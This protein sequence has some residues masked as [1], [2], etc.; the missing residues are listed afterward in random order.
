MDSAIVEK[1]NGGLLF[2]YTAK[3][4]REFYENLECYLGE[5]FRDVKFSI[6]VCAEEIGYFEVEYLTGV[7]LSSFERTVVFSQ[8]LDEVCRGVGKSV[9]ESGDGIS[10]VV[11]GKKLDVFSSKVI[12]AAGGVLGLLVLHSRCELEGDGDLQGIEFVFGH[13][14][15]AYGYIA[16]RDLVA[17]RLLGC[18]AKLEGIGEISGILGEFDL[19]S[20]CAQL[21]SLYISLTEAQVGSIVL[22]GALGSDVEWGLSRC[23]LDQIRNVAGKPVREIVLESGEALLIPRYGPEAGFEAV[24]G[25]GIGSFLC[26]PLV[27]KDKVLGTVNLINASS[28]KGRVFSSLDVATVVTISSLAASAIENVILHNELIEREHIKASLQIARSIQQGMYPVKGLVIP[29]YEMAWVTRCCDETGGD[30]F[31]LFELG[32]GHAAFAIGDVSGHGIGAAL[33]MASGRANLRALLSVKV[34]LRDVVDRLNDLLARDMDDAMFMTL[35]LGSLNHR[36]HVL[37]F[38]NAGHDQPILLRR[39]RGFTE[40]LDTTGLPVG[41]MAGWSFEVRSVAPLEPGDVLVL[42][43]DGVWEAT[44][45]QGERFGKDRLRE[46]LVTAGNESPQQLIDAILKAVE[47]YADGCVH[48]DD[49]TLLVLKRVE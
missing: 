2:L 27:F 28:C 13:V 29:G 33:L 8:E 40:D 20:L 46:V 41:M 10:I 12:E 43:T 18:E 45:R 32:E 22:E 37:S 38:V 24:R 16:E 21:L 19:Y 30:Y 25:F 6:L 35:F 34:D 44:N 49:S 36:N 1:V 31:D 11:D 14:V 39:R 5:L 23:I 7:E 15:S 9:V 17:E 4:R 48:P 3:S 42:S 26:V 47:S